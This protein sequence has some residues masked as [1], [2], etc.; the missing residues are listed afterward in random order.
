MAR[1]SECGCGCGD[2]AK[3]PVLQVTAG[4]FCKRCW[5]KREGTVDVAPVDVAATPRARHK[6]KHCP[7]P[8][9]AYEFKDAPAGVV[10]CPKC[11]TIGEPC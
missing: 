8:D 9:C 5:L 10:Q 7:D 11:G 2:S 1:C 6:P 3:N 4:R